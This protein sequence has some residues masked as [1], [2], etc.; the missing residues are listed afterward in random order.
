MAGGSGCSLVFCR[1]PASTADDLAVQHRTI[2]VAES[3]RLQQLSS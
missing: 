2:D 3:S 1:P